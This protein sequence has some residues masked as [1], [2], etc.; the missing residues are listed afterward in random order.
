MS[1]AREP[2]RFFG[3]SAP[4]GAIGDFHGVLIDILAAKFYNERMNVYLDYAA[5]APLRREVLDEML[6]SA[7]LFANPD[8]LHAP[9]RLAAAALLAARD[10][11]S[12]LTG[13]AD[14]Y[15]TAG[16]TEADNWAV[17]CL[18]EG[19]ILLSPIEHAAVLESA[20]L[21]GGEQFFAAVDGDGIVSA[22]F[23]H[24]MPESVGLVAVMG[25][26][27]EVGSLQPLE[28]LARAAHARGALLFS[29]CVQAACS[30]NLREIMRHADAISL[31]AHKLGGPKGAGALVVK[32]GVKLRP[33]IAGGEQER[34]KRGGTAN[35]AAAVGMA[36]AL[37]LADAERAAFCRLTKALRD[38]FED[39]LLRSLGGRIAIDGANRV[40]NISHVTFAGASSPLL[41]LL[42]L[43]GVYAS[44][45]AACS[46]HAA[47]PSHVLL[48]MGRSAEEA[49]RG[50]R[51]SFGMQTTRE[52]VLFAAR[53]VIDCMQPL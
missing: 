4:H 24:T 47:R 29:D 41:P 36:K 44:G 19:D 3:F 27:N 25:A 42:D 23:E 14:V 30:Q 53:A 48:A 33:L 34:G 7:E 13:G 45:G 16:G 39:A 11:I 10:K 52:E 21:R 35:L 51:F 9:G 6:S 28:E 32:K 17:R 12:A 26:N 5:S 31:S 22:D 2:P 43:K 18:G 20:P 1:N 8:S 46:A 37:E 49:E 50:V 15:F 40:P 38:L